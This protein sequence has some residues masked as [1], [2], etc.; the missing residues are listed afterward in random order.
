[1]NENTIKLYDEN[2]YSTEFT[3]R[4]ISC[5]KIEGE[6]GQYKAVF[7]RTLFFP[8]EGGQTPDRGVVYLLSEQDIERLKTAGTSESADAFTQGENDINVLDVQIKSDIIYHYL[9]KELEEGSTILGKIDF[10]HRFSNMQQHS[11]EHIFSGIVNSKFG[12]DN[13]GFHL[14]D[15]I[16]TMDYSGQLS[17]EELADVELQVNRAIYENRE[18]RAYYPSPEELADID[19]RSKK[20]LTGAVRIV[21]VDGYDVCACCAPH[22]K[23]T[24]EIGILKIVG[25]QN[26]KGGTRVSILCGKRALE[27]LSGEHNMIQ[28]LAG[29]L[30]TSGDNIPNIV[31]KQQ[32]EIATLKRSLSEAG[33]KLLNIEADKVPEDVRNVCL[34]ADKDSDPNVIRRVVNRLVSEREGYCG[35]FFGDDE[36]GYRFII[37]CPDG[38]NSNDV[39]TQL[40][41]SFQVRGGGKPAMVQGSIEGATSDNIMETFGQLG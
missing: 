29:E 41:K 28:E 14:S 40:R 39:L 24:G 4:V 25:F 15:S 1:M 10:S 9:D 23:R 26:Y 21:E 32:E 35:I 19:Y 12:Y 8:E 30:S 31:H 2:A 5:E 3:A 22:V 37:G 16:V 34:L 18:I 13:V 36:S 6:N 20:E 17:P 27:F 33:E 7:D 38:L 11:G